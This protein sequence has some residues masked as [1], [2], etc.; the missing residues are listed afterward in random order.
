MA[1]IVASPY[2]MDLRTVHFR[3]FADARGRFMET[4]RTEWFPDRTWNVVQSN[5]SQSAAGV[6]RGLHYHHHQVDYWQVLEGRIRVALADLRPNSPTYRAT[7]LIELDALEPV[8]LFIPTGVAHG[9]YAVTHAT[10]QYLVDNYYTGG[11]ELGVAWNDPELAIDWGV[12][13]PLLS[14]RDAK[15]PSLRD[16]PSALLPPALPIANA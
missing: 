16:I 13:A 11:D 1:E 10:L 5:R 7:Q 15:N 8:G 6:L 4:F 14:E 12:D 9:F 3:V 2:I